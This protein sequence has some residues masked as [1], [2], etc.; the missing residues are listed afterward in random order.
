MSSISH[1]LV[2]CKISALSGSYLQMSAFLG[3]VSNVCVCTRPS[4]GTQLMTLL[5][6]SVEMSRQEEHDPFRRNKRSKRSMRDS[7][8]RLQQEGS[9]SRI[10]SHAVHTPPREAF[11]SLFT[12]PYSISQQSQLIASHG[13]AHVGTSA[14]WPHLSPPFS[15][16]HFISQGFPPVLS[17][18]G[19]LQGRSS[20][21]KW[22]LRSSPRAL[23]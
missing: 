6:N 2:G 19:P 7:N 21:L 4:V 18:S 3:A 12:C 15:L 9:G 17:P 13:A 8:Q 14:R 22:K 1:A 11:F 10:A 16:T 23:P 5:G 20:R